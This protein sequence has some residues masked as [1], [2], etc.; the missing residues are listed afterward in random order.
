MAEGKILTSGY[1]PAFVATDT[2]FFSAA[3]GAVAARLGGAG[4][5]I[6]V[7]QHL[8][9]SVWPDGIKPDGTPVFR[10]Y[11]HL[12]LQVP[13]GAANTVWVTFDNTTAPVVGGPGMEML[14]GVVYKF[15]NAGDVML[16]PNATGNYLV[17]AG[18]AFQFIA[19]A[20]TNLNIFFAD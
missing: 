19:T 14:P 12:F 5:L 1:L 20:A 4:G 18:T 2:L 8:D 15:E 10:P 11:R 7:P 9:T 13:A 17:N 16:R 6:A 3:V